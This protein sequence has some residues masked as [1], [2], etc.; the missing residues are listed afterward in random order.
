MF[1]DHCLLV[2]CNKEQISG[3]DLVEV[4][5][6]IPLLYFSIDLLHCSPVCTLS[7]LSLPVWHLWHL[8]VPKSTVVTSGI[9]SSLTL[10]ALWA[11]VH[12][13]SA[14]FSK[15]S[16]A[17]KS[18]CVHCCALDFWWVMP[19]IFAQH[20][21][22]PCDLSQKMWLVQEV[23]MEQLGLSSGTFQPLL[24]PWCRTAGGNH[25]RH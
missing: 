5:M 16:R 12:H 6:L 23:A 18:L 15:G 24:H 20:S 8:P 17:V 4:S 22:V 2:W 1:A 25:Y 3:H 10:S 19:T 9:I 13:H 11:L 7:C 21:C 14:L